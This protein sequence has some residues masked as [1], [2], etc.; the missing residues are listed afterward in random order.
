MSPLQWLRDRDPDPAALRQAMAAMDDARARMEHHATSQVSSDERISEFISALDP[1]FRAH[2]LSFAAALV[3]RSMLKV[4]K[5][6]RSVQS[7]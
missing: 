5:Q 3:G 1:S 2:E 6:C 4:P 7:R